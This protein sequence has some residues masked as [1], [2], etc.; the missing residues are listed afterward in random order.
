MCNVFKY[1]YRVGQALMVLKEK[2]GSKD[3]MASQVTRADQAHQVSCFHTILQTDRQKIHILELSHFK[4]MVLM[5]GSV[6][7]YK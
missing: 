6:I 5:S 7:C 4:Q 2:L 3:S 1:H